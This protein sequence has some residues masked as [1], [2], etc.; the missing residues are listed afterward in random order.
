MDHIAL[1]AWGLSNLFKGL[2][3]DYVSND[4]MLAYGL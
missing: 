4:C 3:D 2:S 1:G